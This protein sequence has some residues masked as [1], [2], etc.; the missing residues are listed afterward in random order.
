LFK[1]PLVT[2]A[3]NTFALFNRTRYQQ[4]LG[5]TASQGPIGT[6]AGDDDLPTRGAI[7]SFLRYAADRL[8]ADRENAFW[9][10]LVNSKTTGLTNLTSAL[11]TAPGPWLRDWAISVFADD[12]A[13]GVDPR[14]QQLSWNVRSIITGDGTSVAFPLSTRLLTNNVTTP[15]TLAGYGV[16]FLRFSVAN[17]QD[18]LLTVTSGGQ[19]LSSTVQLSLIRVR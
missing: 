10:N 4:Y 2:T 5:Q 17:G 8:G 12:N 13:A 15:L 9:F 3:Y 14:Y 18:A 16:S 7:W 19:P 1:D 6:D 11:G